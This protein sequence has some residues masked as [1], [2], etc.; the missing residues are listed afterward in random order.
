MDTVS[1]PLCALHSGSI[2]EADVG[3]DPRMR[4][5]E[6]ETQ[7]DSGNKQMTDGEEK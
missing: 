6:L 2:E 1:S 3:D 5:S 4:D 7:A